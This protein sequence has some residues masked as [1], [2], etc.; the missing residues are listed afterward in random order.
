MSG[1]NHTSIFSTAD[2][3]NSGITDLFEPESDHLDL[4]TEHGFV[5]QNPDE[6]RD[7]VTVNEG[8]DFIYPMSPR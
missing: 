3:F 1:H 5:L 6:D 2:L 8:R 4:V 7:T